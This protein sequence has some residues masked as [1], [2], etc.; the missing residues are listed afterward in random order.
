MV[1]LSCEWD[2]HTKG[3]NEVSVKPTTWGSAIMDTT[4][5]LVISVCFV[6]VEVF[7]KNVYFEL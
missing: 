3:A 2:A 7:E 6:S 5:L 4:R 1:C